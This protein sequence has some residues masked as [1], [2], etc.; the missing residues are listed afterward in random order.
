M[1]DSN[2]SN[3]TTGSCKTGM[4]IKVEEEEFSTTIY[5]VVK[6]FQFYYMNHKT[7][8]QPSNP[9]N[10]ITRFKDLMRPSVK[11]K[12]L[13]RV[14]RKKILYYTIPKELLK[15]STKTCI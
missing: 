7:I 8:M 12:R 13:Y 11:M 2:S 9:T 15:I 6:T 3:T 5:C 10:V 14:M 4:K 1:V